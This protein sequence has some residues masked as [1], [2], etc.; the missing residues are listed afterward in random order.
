MPAAEV[1]QV[2]GVHLEGGD[3]PADEGKSMALEG[4]CKRLDPGRLPDA[5]PDPRDISL[6][7][8]SMPSANS[9][10]SF[11]YMESVSAIFRICTPCTREAPPRIAEATWTASVI[12]PRLEP[13]SRDARVNASMQ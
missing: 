10:L 5:C 12:S 7:S 9:T 11:P 4:A 3:L 8:V 2:P 13:F 6:R 1:A